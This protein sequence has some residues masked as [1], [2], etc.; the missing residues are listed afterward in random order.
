MTIGVEVDR[1]FGVGESDVLVL[2]EGSDRKSEE[3]RHGG[4]K[5]DVAYDVRVGRARRYEPRHGGV[6]LRVGVGLADWAH[7]GDVAADV[8]S[9]FPCLCG[10]LL[11]DVRGEFLDDVAVGLSPLN[12][13]VASTPVTGAVS[14]SV[15]TD[16]WRSR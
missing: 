3:A 11:R 10:P 4:L 6:V 5:V 16:F 15:A 14:S 8:V 13:G 12:T 2:V 9:D 1:G 7:P